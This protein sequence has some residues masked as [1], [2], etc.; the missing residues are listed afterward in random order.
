M[1]DAIERPI[2]QCWRQGRSGA[3]APATMSKKLAEVA[4]DAR[5]GHQ[6]QMDGRER[7]FGIAKK[8]RN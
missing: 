8:L 7:L 4:I 1:A 3:V 2:E 6:T 5:H